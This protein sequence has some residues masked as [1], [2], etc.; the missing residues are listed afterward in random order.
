MS[1]CIKVV[2]QKKIGF[3]LK[4][5]SFQEDHILGKKGALFCGKN[6]QFS[7]MGI[8]KIINSLLL[9]RKLRSKFRLC[10]RSNN[11]GFHSFLAFYIL[12]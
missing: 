10:L 11:N 6:C 5:K 8:L 12:Q 2:K 3:L 9:R 7:V 1:S 4:K